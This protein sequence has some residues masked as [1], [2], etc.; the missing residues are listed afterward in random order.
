MFGLLR[1]LKKAVSQPTFKEKQ[2]TMSKIFEA[3][4]AATMFDA[5]KK[6]LGDNFVMNVHPNGNIEIVTEAVCQPDETPRTQESAEVNEDIVQEPNQQGIICDTSTDVEAN[7]YVKTF[8]TDRDIY[9]EVEPLR[10]NMYIVKFPEMFNI[11]PN[12]VM[13]AGPMRAE[14][15]KEY[16][17]RWSPI[18]FN[19]MQDK[20]VDMVTS[21]RN[22]VLDG[23]CTP[24]KIQYEIL[25]SKKNV[26]QIYTAMGCEVIRVETTPFS[27]YNKEGLHSITLVVQPKVCSLWQ[28]LEDEGK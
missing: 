11:K 12:L 25:D 4:M 21:I 17:V 19:I 9:P 24:F 15:T 13:Y 5:A 26:V 2:K 20:N 23:T 1:F 8:E 14:I 6:N 27:Y 28:T 7:P 18:E 10:S 16:G 3:E 22:L